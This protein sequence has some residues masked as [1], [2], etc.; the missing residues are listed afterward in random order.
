MTT[1]KIVS[2][3]LEEQH[4]KDMKILA[5]QLDKSVEQLTKEAF[6]DLLKKYEYRSPLKKY[7]RRPYQKEEPA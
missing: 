6:L 1:K 5:V 3:R 2:T 4:I 7:Q